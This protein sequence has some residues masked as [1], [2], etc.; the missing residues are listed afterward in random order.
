VT[1]ALP[2]GHWRVAEAQSRLG[3]CLADR[4][5]TAEAEPLLV[6]GYE[7]LMRGRGAQNARTA[8][9]LGRLVAFYDSQGNATA[10][11]DYRARIPR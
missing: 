4:G 11:A 2:A 3:G 1:K 10:A 7:G 9:A 6:A 5:K 8:A